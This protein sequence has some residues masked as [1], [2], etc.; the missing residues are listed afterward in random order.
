[1]TSEF[2]R[3]QNIIKS[4][5]KYKSIFLRWENG[6]ITTDCKNDK[7]FSFAYGRLDTAK[8][9][10]LDRLVIIDSDVKYN[11]EIIRNYD[12]NKKPETCT[13]TCKSNRI[14]FNNGDSKRLNNM[15]N[16]ERL[17]FAK[18]QYELARLVE[19]YKWV[20]TKEGIKYIIKVLD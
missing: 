14:D 15:D 10:D 6:K 8:F 19:A 18:S 13:L 9:Y 17:R 12:K 20:I 16:I 1:M 4:K 7:Q 2:Y 5:K 11:I 3:D